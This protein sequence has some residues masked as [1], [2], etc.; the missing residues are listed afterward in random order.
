MVA[1]RFKTRKLIAFIGFCLLLAAIAVVTRGYVRELNWDETKYYAPAIRFAALSWPHLPLRDYHLPA[2]PLALWLQAAVAVHVEGRVSL[3]LFSSLCA[4]GLA[5]YLLWRADENPLGVSW[6]ADVLLGRQAAARLCGS[7]A[8]D[9][10]LGMAT[11]PGAIRYRGHFHWRLAWRALLRSN[12][13]ELV[14]FRTS[15]RP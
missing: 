13:S 5:A 7:D 14:R 9:D 6:F 3:R 11:P 4:V 10:R 12:A 15:G 2:P 1:I 8:E